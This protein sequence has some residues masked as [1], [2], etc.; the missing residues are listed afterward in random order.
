MEIIIVLRNVVPGFKEPNYI[1]ESIL[2]EYNWKIKRIIK[3]ATSELVFIPNE[4]GRRLKFDGFC[5]F[6]FKNKNSQEKTTQKH[7]D[8]MTNGYIFRPKKEVFVSGGRYFMVLRLAQQRWEL[9]MTLLLGSPWIFKIISEKCSSM[10]GGHCLARS[11][12]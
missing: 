8:L 9:Y 7:L 2:E 6:H 1:K 12:F 5:V 4:A 3:W 10:S 11:L